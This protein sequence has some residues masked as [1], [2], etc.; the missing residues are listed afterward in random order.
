MYSDNSLCGTW[1][2]RSSC[3]NC[4]AGLQ[5]LF[6]F[7][8]HRYLHTQWQGFIPGRHWGHRRQTPTGSPTSQNTNHTLFINCRCYWLMNSFSCSCDRLRYLFQKQINNRQWGTLSRRLYRWAGP[9]GCLRCRLSCYVIW[10]FSDLAGK[11]ADRTWTIKRDNDDI[12]CEW[13]MYLLCFLIVI[14]TTNY[15][16]SLRI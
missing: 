2:I 11:S 12:H 16:N 5:N 14:S 1:L 9:I 15:V 4:F 13:L 3:K 6:S 10:S 7:T 8:G